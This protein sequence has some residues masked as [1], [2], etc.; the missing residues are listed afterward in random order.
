MHKRGYCRQPSPDHSGVHSPVHPRTHGRGRGHDAVDVAFASAGLEVDPHTKI[1]DLHA[2]DRLLLGVALATIDRPPFLVVDDLHE[3][4]T[5]DERELVF[6]RL[7]GLADSGV[8]IVVGSLD[9]AL[10]V[11]ADSVLVLDGDGRPAGYGD[12]GDRSDSRDSRDVDDR[13]A[14]LGAGLG[15]EADHATAASPIPHLE[16]TADALV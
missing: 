12:A 14:G 6:E 2:A 16:E 1:A 13:A 5:P 3:D 7:R 10:A 4:L 15:A 8:T 9:P 11:L